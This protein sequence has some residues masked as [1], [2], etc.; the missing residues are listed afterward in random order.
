MTTARRHYV[1]TH[2]P[3]HTHPHTIHTP[4]HTP[5]PTNKYWQHTPKVTDAIKQITTIT[6]PIVT[7]LKTAGQILVKNILLPWDNS[8]VGQGHLVI[9][10]SWPKSATPHSVWHLWT[11]DQPF[12]E[13]STWQ[14]TTLTTDRHPWPRWDL[15]PQS[16]QAH[17]RPRGHAVL[18]FMKKRKTV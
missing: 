4:T 16:Q 14:Q 8:I 6:D 11:S 2:T 18:N 17:L 1:D 5:V 7:K 10:D 3:T 12:A 9:E 13:T 15:N